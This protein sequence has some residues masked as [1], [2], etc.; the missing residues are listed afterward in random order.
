MTSNISTN[1]KNLLNKLPLFTIISVFVVLLILGIGIA[2]AYYFE[3]VT[4]GILA[5]KVG[6]FNVGNGDINMIINRQNDNGSYDRVYVVPDS[7]YIFNDS[8]TKCSIPCNDGQDI[9]SYNFDPV[10]RTFSLTSSK[11]VT[12]KFYFD[13]TASSDINIYMLVEDINGNYE[14]DSKKYTQ[15]DFI[16]AYGYKYTNKYICDAEATVTYDSVTK[17]FN[18]ATASKNN[19][20]VYFEKVG[21]ADIIVNTY[22]QEEVGSETYTIVNSIPSNNVYTLNSS[23]SVC[24]PVSDTTPAGIISYV[25]GYINVD[26]T[27]K[28]ICDVYLNLE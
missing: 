9:C 15:K 28:Q 6:D 1:K 20:Y 23:L 10:N 18:I 3:S 25:D 26:A 17:K 5:N 12:C 19:C 11:K 22:I 24:T 13:K 27:G 16:P 2:Y 8:L 14:Y 7:Y 4:S 21:N